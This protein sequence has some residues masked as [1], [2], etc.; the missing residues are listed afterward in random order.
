MTSDLLPQV[1]H[2]LDI[3]WGGEVDDAG[4]MFK[5]CGL[6]LYTDALFVCVWPHDEPHLHSSFAV[7]SRTPDVEIVA[8]DFAI[9][10]AGS[11]ALGLWDVLASPGGHVVFHEDHEAMIRTCRSR[12]N[13]RAWPVL[14]SH[15]VSVVYLHAVFGRSNMSLKCGQSE[16]LAMGTYKEAFVNSNS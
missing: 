14:R 6:H 9:R 15:R 2:Q 5:D 10:H 16:C 7:R 13:P 8:A 1:L 3:A 12:R 11:L 4:A